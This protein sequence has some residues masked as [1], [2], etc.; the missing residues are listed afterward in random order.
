VDRQPEIGKNGM[1]SRPFA[2][3]LPGLACLLLLL[4]PT[5][6]RADAGGEISGLELTP[7][8]RWQMRQL[9]ES[10]QQ[11]SRSFEAADGKEAIY[12]DQMA[13]RVRG[14]GMERLPD[15]AIAA[16]AYA[17]QAAEQGKPDRAEVALA[18][19]RR[20]DDGRPEVDFAAARV[21]RAK[22]DW[23]G[24][25]GGLVSG[26][27][28]KL[29]APVEGA[30]AVYNLR[31]WIFYTVL[32][33]FGCFI[34]LLMAAEGGALFYDLARLLSPPLPR[35]AADLVAVLLLLWPLVLPSGFLWLALYWSVLLWAYATGRERAVLVLAWIALGSSPILMAQQQR[36]LR[37]SLSPPTRLLENLGTDRLYGAL[38]SDT[39]ALVTMLPKNP[40]V[41]ELVADIHRRLGQWDYAR[42]IYTEIS[43]DSEISGAGSAIAYNNIGVYH[44]RRKEYETAITYFTRAKDA[45]PQLAQAYFNMGQ[46]YAQLYDFNNSHAA[47]GQAKTV[48]S[49]LVERWNARIKGVDPAEAVVAADGGAERSREVQRLLAEVWSGSDR[50]SSF[51]D[52]WRRHSALIASLSALLLAIALGQARQQLGFRSSALDTTPKLVQSPLARTFLPGLDSANEDQ[53][54]GALLAVL[55]VVALAV[56]AFLCRVAYHSPI[57]FDPSCNL[58]MA[59]GLGGLLLLFLIRWRVCARG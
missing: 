2:L 11:W 48:S 28:K 56:L 51:T 30:M 29:A 43:Q 41:T 22:G 36:A 24:F 15:L 9:H 39:E 47:M 42:A 38:F 1:S 54:F 25:F 31:L 21:S 19:A 32:L 49:A 57:A 35:R 14:L 20:L 7:Q 3:R 4:L 59:A 18:A 27:R 40:A 45:D 50:K 5:A 33:S 55:P 13:E 26:E 23:G 34:V 16:A 44:H 17:V 46:S 37:M 6:A 8:V 53:A 52:L 58:G 10:W 12:L